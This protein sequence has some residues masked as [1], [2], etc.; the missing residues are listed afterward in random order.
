MCQLNSPLLYLFAPDARRSQGATNEEYS[1]LIL[2]IFCSFED[3][4]LI[5]ITT[6][7][8]HASI[9]KQK[10]F[11]FILPVLRSGSTSVKVNLLTENECSRLG[12]MRYSAVSERQ[13]LP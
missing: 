8:F 7:A 12:L 2:R 4:M 1:A 5:R 3:V 10:N 11:T 6:A 13:N 9:L